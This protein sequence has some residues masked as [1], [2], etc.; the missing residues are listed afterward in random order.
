MSQTQRIT[1]IDSLRGMAVILMVMVHAAATWNPFQGEQHSILAYVVSGLG[2]LAAPL[3]VTL[4]GWGVIRSRL[5]LKQIIFRKFGMS[6]VMKH[7]LL[8]KPVLAQA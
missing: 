3:F 8:L 7:S 6:T 2:G 1:H 5:T 4:F